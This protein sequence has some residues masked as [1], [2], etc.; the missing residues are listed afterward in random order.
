[1]FETRRHE[2]LAQIKAAYILANDGA[3]SDVINRLGPLMEKDAPYEFLA[4]GLMGFAALKSG[5]ENLAREQFGYLESIP[6]VP[7]TIKE[8]AK[9]NLSLMRTADAAAAMQAPEPVAPET[10]PLETATPETP[11]TQIETP[12][13]N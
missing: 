3:Y 13:E 7:A 10:A 4:R 2:Q 5:D 8:R 11:T 6:G 1:V 9:Q 12:N